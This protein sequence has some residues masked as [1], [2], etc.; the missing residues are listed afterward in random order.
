MFIKVFQIYPAIGTLP[1]M[2]IPLII[3]TTKID[4]VGKFD[5]DAVTVY[6]NGDDTPLTF[7]G[8]LER[9]ADKLKAE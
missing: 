8:S 9:W 3:N 1:E 6:M 2:A 5:D 7:Q 4:S